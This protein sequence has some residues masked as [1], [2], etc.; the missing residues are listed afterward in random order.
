MKQIYLATRL[1]GLLFGL[2]I[3][4]SCSKFDFDNIKTD[5]LNTEWGVPL[6]Q[7][8]L[9]LADFLNDTSGTI[10]TNEDG[11]ISLIYESKELVSVE[12]SERTKIPDQLE[13]ETEVFTIPQP[14]VP[15]PQ[16]TWVELP[17][18]Y[19]NITFDLT[20]EGQRIDSLYLTN[21]LYNLSALTNLNMDSSILH[22][23]VPNFISTLNGNPLEYTFKISNPQGGSLTLNTDV[24]L[25]DFYAQ[26]EN[27]P[28]NTIIIVADV[29][30][31]TDTNVNLLP[32]Y[33]L[34]LTNELT[35]IEYSRF[36]GFIGNHIES[37]SDTIDL[38][39]Y[40]SADFGSISFGPECVRLKVDFY[41][42]LGLPVKVEA[43]KFTAYHTTGIN[44]DSLDIYLFS[45]DTAN[46][47][48]INSPDCN[49]AL[50]SST[51]VMLNRS[52]IVEA[53][54]IAPNKIYFKLNG[55]FNYE[56]DSLITNCFR[57]TS[58][59]NIAV[60]VE[61]DLYGS[62]SDFTIADT[63]DFSIESVENLNA[64][65]LR[66]D[67]SNGFPIN[68]FAQLDF[69]DSENQLLYS[70]FPDNEN[71]IVSAITGNPPDC[72]VIQPSK[73]E[74]IVTIIGDDLESLLKASHIIFKS[75]LSTEPDK[76]VKIYSDYSI[77]LNLSAKLYVNY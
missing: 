36:Y 69:I 35:N 58:Q 5:N 37:Y 22:L 25:I 51:E 63:L 28:L 19:F 8:K 43:E 67:I 46:S 16:G 61:M 29:W 73:K 47:F 4:N 32:E 72:R 38:N 70:L 71:I 44:P 12:A 17:P 3:I 9:T 56:G 33:S 24:D 53:L 49:S 23:T 59:I 75:T 66:I 7:S 52:N 30:I 34:T 31:K 10:H 50:P 45:P 54:E 42:E 40:N 41:N 21:G 18:I 48:I 76:L 65:E 20:N 74:T 26:F 6:V 13:I 64:I 27:N 77:D 14:P 2:L 55:L 62:I 15:L 39:I 1:L 60:S 57:D 11:L 68:A